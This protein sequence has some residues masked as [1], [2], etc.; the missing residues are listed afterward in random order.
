L[1]ASRFGGFENDFGRP[2]PTEL[3]EV[4]TRRVISDRATSSTRSAL[5]AKRTSAKP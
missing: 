1:A 2:N 5:K 4:F 3:P